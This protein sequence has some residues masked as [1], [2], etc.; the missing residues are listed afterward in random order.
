MDLGLSIEVKVQ[1]IMIGLIIIYLLFKFMPQLKYDQKITNVKIKKIELRHEMKFGSGIPILF[2]TF[3]C[4]DNNGDELIF[5]KRIK[6]YEQFKYRFDRLHVGA[7][8]NIIEKKYY[9]MKENQKRY[10]ESE[11]SEIVKRS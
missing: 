1:I 8:C 3:I 7:N 10:V 4:E 5:K 9:K 11:I 2:Y 6:H